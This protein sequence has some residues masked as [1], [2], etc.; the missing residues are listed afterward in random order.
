MMAPHYPAEVALLQK[1]QALGGR[2]VPQARDIFD[3][4]LLL[5]RERVRKIGSRLTPDLMEAARLRAL[6]LSFDDFK[7]QVLAYLDPGDRA[8]YDS[9][10]TW[11]A[12]QLGVIEMLEDAP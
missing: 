3:L 10:E 4:H 8:A 6:D 11:E 7:G 9:P 12:M 2:S 5:S 1:L